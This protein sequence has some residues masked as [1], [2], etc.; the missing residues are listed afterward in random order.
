MGIAMFL[1]YRNLF[2]L[3]VAWIVVVILLFMFVPVLKVA[4][5]IAG[6]GFIFIPCLLLFSEFTKSPKNKVVI[7]WSVVFLLF[8]ALPIFLLRV[9]NWETD[10]KDLTLFGITGN[11][12]HRTSNFLYAMVMVAVADG[13]RKERRALK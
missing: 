1:T 9:L 6:A 4:S 13:W 5:V 2:F 12:L 11:Q 3:L 10:F 7:F 8:A